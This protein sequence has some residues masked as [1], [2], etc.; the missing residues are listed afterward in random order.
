MKKFELRDADDA[1][2]GE[3]LFEYELELSRRVHMTERGRVVV[4]TA[5]PPGRL[6]DRW[7]EIWAAVDGVEALAQQYGDHD[8]DNHEEVVIRE[9]TF[10][11]RCPFT[12]ELKF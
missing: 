12:A 4:V 3:V 2:E 7:E 9:K 5:S 11:K 8:E 10:T 6:K 1:P